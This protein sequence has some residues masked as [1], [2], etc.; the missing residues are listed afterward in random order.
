VI[1]TIIILFLLVSI[2]IIENDPMYYKS[3]DN[4]YAIFIPLFIIFFIIYIFNPY[5]ITNL[6]YHSIIGS[7]VT[8][9]Y[10]IQVFL[11]LLF[12][13]P[14]QINKLF[15]DLLNNIKNAFIEYFINPIKILYNTVI[16]KINEDEI[17]KEEFNKQLI[18]TGIFSTFILFI[19]AVLVYAKFDDRS[20]GNM[21]YFYTFMVFIPLII[22]LFVSSML[23]TENEISI[24]SKLFL[25]SSI[26]ITFGLAYCYSKHINP[27]NNIYIYSIGNVFLF[28]ML[29]IFLAGIFIIFA[30]YLKR[31]KGIFGFIINLIF[32]IPCLLTDFIQYIKLQIGI[33]PNITY[34]L[35]ILELILIL[36]YIYLPSMIK[37]LLHKNSVKLQ[38][39]PY[40]LNKK[41]I[42]AINNIFQS[43]TSYDTNKDDNYVNNNY[44]FSFW[45]YL[46][47]NSIYV[48]DDNL[49][50]NN[51]RIIF[52]FANGRPKLVYINDEYY[53]DIWRIYLSNN[54][55]DS[56]T[57]CSK[58]QSKK[59]Y[60]D[61]NGLPKQ[62]WNLFVINYNGNSSD[63]FINGELK[64]SITFNEDNMPINIREIDTATIG[65]DI[66]GLNGAIKESYYYNRSL[67]NFEIVNMYNLFNTF[68][69]F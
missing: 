46:N 47:E 26:L 65:Q 52:N 28:L 10:G 56:D 57:T 42:V 44:A 62:R 20:S 6:L 64:G 51:E 53:N 30:D 24:Y 2:G 11:F 55:N 41:N 4:N 27:L 13:I 29:I 18:N 3:N 35:F 68:G 34:I 50:K 54:C 66:D 22:G 69:T 9:I 59:D 7:I 1:I 8:I 58:E 17:V 14:I 19:F 31:Q 37:F 15:P 49:G 25:F 60:I 63:V 21:M 38:R 23:V 48:K 45:V 67:S 40:Y 36:A 32:F 33:T 5:F 43:K 61:F 16:K 39:N 12:I